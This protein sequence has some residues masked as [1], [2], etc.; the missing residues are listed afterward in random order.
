LISD[1]KRSAN[2]YAI[3]SVE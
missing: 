2:A 3:V 1:E